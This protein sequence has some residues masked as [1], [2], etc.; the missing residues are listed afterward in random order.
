MGEQN[1]RGVPVALS[2]RVPGRFD[3]VLD[4]MLRQ[5]FPG[6]AIGV[7]GSPRWDNFSVF[8][9]WGSCLD[10]LESHDIAWGRL[11]DFPILGPSRESPSNGGMIGHDDLL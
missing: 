10:R 3:E 5:V 8:G 2:P 11:L 6:A 4:L 9:G 1:R 7:S